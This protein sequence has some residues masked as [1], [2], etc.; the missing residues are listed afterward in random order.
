MDSKIGFA[1][2]STVEQDL[3]IQ[4]EK[5]KACGCSRIF[6]GKHSGKE[7]ANK[8]AL[9]QLL[10]YVREGDT[11]VV[12]KIDRFGRSLSQVL[13]MIDKLTAKG[14]NLVAIEQSVDTANNDPMSRAMI[15]LLGM[16]AEME[17]NF[18]IS[19]TQEG[20]V[21]SGNFGGRPL[22]LDKDTR[23]LIRER[24]SRG[25]SKLSLSKEFNVS[26]TT[27]LNIANENKSR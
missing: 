12:T 20:K 14:V 3:T 27:I 16:F 4:V 18:I 15:Q 5:L 21:A 17:R 25:D 8:E 19:R 6:S 23:D 1:R 2:V 9:E 10:D 24:L 7:E 22:T 26:R 13:S 11:V